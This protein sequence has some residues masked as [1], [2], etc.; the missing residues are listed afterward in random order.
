MVL[1]ADTRNCVNQVLDSLREGVLNQ[2]TSPEAL[3]NNLQRAVSLLGRSVENELMGYLKDGAGGNLSATEK[4]L[5]AL[6]HLQGELQRSGYPEPAQSIARFLDGV[7]WMQLTNSA[8]DPAQNQWVQLEVPIQ[9]ANPHVTPPLQTE[10]DFETAHLRIAR[11]NENPA[12]PLDPQNTRLVIQMDLADQQSIQIDLTVIQNR[13]G[14]SISTSTD[15]LCEIARE[16][17]DS[18]SAGLERIGYELNPSQ[19]NVQAVQPPVESTGNRAGEITLGAI[20][21]ET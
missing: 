6:N 10:S 21:L 18:L 3:R 20:D 17:L 4:G 9:M 13:I 1:P 8:S 11:Q 19:V 15:E 16:E 14:A 5:L 12:Q 2:S 7:R